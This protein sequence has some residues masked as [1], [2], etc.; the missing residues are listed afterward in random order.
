MTQTR[1]AHSCFFFVSMCSRVLGTEAIT[2][3]PLSPWGYER[4]L[5]ALQ[6]MG[7]H[8]EAIQ[9]YNSILSALEQFADSKMQRK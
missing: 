3:N 4:K 5:A 2:L 7:R 8:D 6:G 9:A 1:Y